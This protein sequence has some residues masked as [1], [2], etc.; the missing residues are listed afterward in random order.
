MVKKITLS[1]A[2][3]GCK[4]AFDHLDGR[5]IVVST[6]QNQVIIPD[7]VKIIQREGM[8]KRGNQFDKGDLY[9]KFE[10]EFPKSSQLTGEVVDA[11]KKCTYLLNATENIDLKSEEVFQCQIK[12]ANIKQ[13]ENSNNMKQIKSNLK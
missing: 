2:L 11:L 1:E 12:D 10:I 6:E 5:K 4:F 3:V 8:P 9:I 7:S 13:F